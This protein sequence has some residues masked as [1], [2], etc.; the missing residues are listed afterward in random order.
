MSMRIICCGTPYRGDD[1]AGLLVAE[2]L[3]QLG[4]EVFTCM[5]E[6]T[7]LLCVMDGADDVLVVDAAVT[8]A[9]AGTIHEWHHRTSQFQHNSSTTHSLGVA[10][11]I[12]LGR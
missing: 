11:G 12:A 1:G 10:E 6:A 9:P 8:G 2:R 4:I 3:Q 7:D 5:G